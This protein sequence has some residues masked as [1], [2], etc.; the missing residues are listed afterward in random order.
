[1]Y[2]V[3]KRWALKLMAGA[4]RIYLCSRRGAQSE[5]VI[6]TETITESIRISDSVVPMTGWCWR[7]REY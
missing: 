2:A 4:M 6:S 3:A 1:M 7:S 5:L